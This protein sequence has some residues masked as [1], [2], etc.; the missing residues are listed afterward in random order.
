MLQPCACRPPRIR[1]MLAVPGR[2]IAKGDNEIPERE[3][4]FYPSSGNHTYHMGKK[5]IFNGVHFRNK[6][7]VSERT[8]EMCIGKKK[9]V[10]EIASRNGIPLATPG[11][12]PYD[13]PE[14]STDFHK[15]GSTMP[16]VN[17]GGAMYKKRSDTVIPLQRLPR[18][19]CV[20]FLIKKKQQELEKE[21][22]E[23]KNLDI[24]KPAPKLVHYFSPAGQTRKLTFQQL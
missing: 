16:P 19:P 12:H 1:L 3:W 13:C 20:P 2:G 8:L 7:T 6:I 11:D 24:W 22:V 10:T 4:T 17:F 14:Q 23:V 18:L 5:C 9:Y 21:K 15:I